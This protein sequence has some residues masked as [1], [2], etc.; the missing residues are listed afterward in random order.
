MTTIS[1][2][3]I[4]NWLLL[5]SILLTFTACPDDDT[6]P[7]FGFES[8]RY[9]LWKNLLDNNYTFDYLGDIRD[10]GTYPDHLEQSFDRDHQ[11]TGGI[12][13]TGLIMQL[14]ES[15]ERLAEVDIALLGVG[16]NDLLNNSGI[17]VQ[18]I[19]DNL[20]TIIDEL[21]AANPNIVILIEQIAP[22]RA[23]FMTEQLRTLFDSYNAGIPTIANNQSDANSM[24][25]V[26]D[27]NTD[28]QESYFADEVHYN[29]AGAKEV[30][31][32]YFAALQPFL[33]AGE[34][35]NILPIGD[36]RVEGFRP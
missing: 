35:Y 2:F 5:T 9:E 12:E 24:I 21:Q 26:V 6:S 22:G 30:A 25:I 29:E 13:T 28:W 34:S 15:I 19:L 1:N 14:D 7:M 8:Y 32:R 4:L 23:D 3:K 33:S 17:D 27:M 20:N 11:G 31:D 16:G 10:S 18:Q 36:S